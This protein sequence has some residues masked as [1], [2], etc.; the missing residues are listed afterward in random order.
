MFLIIMSKITFDISEK[1]LNK[2]EVK[3]SDEDILFLEKL[4]VVMIN[5]V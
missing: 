1:I 5:I 3:I 4:R 2:N